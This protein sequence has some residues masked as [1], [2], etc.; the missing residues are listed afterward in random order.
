MEEV[1]GAMLCARTVSTAPTP[2]NSNIKSAALGI[3]FAL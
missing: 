2:I 3:Q 1:P